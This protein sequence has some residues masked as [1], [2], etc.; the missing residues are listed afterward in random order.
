MGI[1]IFFVVGLYLF[2][3]GVCALF[4]HPIFYTKRSLENIAPDVIPAYLKEVGV[5]NV[6]TGGLFLAKAISDKFFPGNMV[7]QVI[8]LVLLVLCVIFL[9][10]SNEK[11]LKK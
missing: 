9:A 11:Y 10:K 6:V 2:V 7:L 4:G 1:T 5:W 8:F 3:R